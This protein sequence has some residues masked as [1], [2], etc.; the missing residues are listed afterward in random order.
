MAKAR[1]I[2]EEEAEDVQEA[3]DFAALNQASGGDLFA[4][5]DELRTT[6]AGDVVFIVNRLLPVDQRGT[7]AKSPLPSSI[8]K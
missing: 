6:G 1:I 2:P 3:Q 8:W 5:V 7:A 4:A